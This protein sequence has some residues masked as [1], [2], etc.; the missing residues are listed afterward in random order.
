M[1]NGNISRMAHQ[2]A[3]SFYTSNRDVAYAY[4]AQ[5]C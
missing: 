5:E 1:A 2:M 3:S 4:D